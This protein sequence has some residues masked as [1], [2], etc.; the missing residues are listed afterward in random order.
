MSLSI[1]AH[2]LLINRSL[3]VFGA[4]IL[5]YDHLITFDKEYEFFW[6]PA[7]HW[8][9]YLFL[10]HRYSALFSNIT[11][12]CLLFTALDSETEDRSFLARQ[13]QLIFSQ[14]LVAGLLCLRVYALYGCRPFV[15]WFLLVF[16]SALSGIAIWFIFGPQ[17]P[18]SPPGLGNQRGLSNTSA[19]WVAGAWEAELLFD[20]TIFAM[21]MIKTWRGWR[22]TDQSSSRHIGLPRLLFRD[23]AMYFVIM[24]LATLANIF[25]FYFCQ[26]FLKGSLSTFASAISI[27]M[28]SRLIFNLHDNTKAGNARY[29]NGANSDVLMTSVNYNFYP[30]WHGESHHVGDV[31]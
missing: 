2:D 11:F 5:A 6:Q 22:A 8:T 23:G 3:H 18:V 26:A 1:A 16:S 20:V 10:L 19:I 30:V 14:M 15:K 4:S 31:E 24:L 7:K 9:T 28:M 29:M 13:L 12:T 21:T 17:Y 25:T 27:T